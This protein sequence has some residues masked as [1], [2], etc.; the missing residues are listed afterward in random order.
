MNAPETPVGGLAEQIDA[1]RRQNFVLLLALIVVSFTVA[2]YLRYQ[3]HLS[4]Q[5]LESIRPPANA[6]IQNYNAMM[7]TG[8]VT[9]MMNFLSQL[10]AYAATHPDFQP[11]L[12][13]YGW[14]P[15][16]PATL[17]K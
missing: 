2:A 5:S 15:P 10:S 12:R 8:N 9:N 13:K 11:V 6:M 17:K 14:T 16:A 1:V 7:A 4:H 3:A